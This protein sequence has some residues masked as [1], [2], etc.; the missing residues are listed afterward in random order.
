MI[1]RRYSNSGRLRLYTHNKTLCL[2]IKTLAPVVDSS[3]LNHSDVYR[4]PSVSL[5]RRWVNEKGIQNKC[6][7]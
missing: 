3:E 2:S 4:D 6:P 5:L 7:R 1:F